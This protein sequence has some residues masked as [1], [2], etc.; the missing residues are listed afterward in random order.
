MAFANILDIPGVTYALH[1]YVPASSGWTTTSATPL[2]VVGS[3]FTIPGATD[4]SAVAIE[5]TSF[6]T[7]VLPMDGR[8]S[9]VNVLGATYPNE[10]YGQGVTVV[11]A[12]DSFAAQVGTTTTNPF[13]AAATEAVDN[14]NRFF[15]LGTGLPPDG[16]FIS[17]D[18][19][20]ELDGTFAVP[21]FWQAFDGTFE[22][23]SL[24]KLPQLV[25]VPAFPGVVGQDGGTVCFPPP[26][27]PPGGG[28]PPVGGGGGAGS[29][30][31]GGGGLP[32][33]ESICLPLNGEMCCRANQTAPWVCYPL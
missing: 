12:L 32:P 17:G 10:T 4:W 3:A 18:L 13:S 1:Y 29:S 15:V 23:G 6:G 33:D 14:D 2:A 25:A 5:I 7:G 16:Q 24:V 30:G 20:V 27:D 22:D 21:D 28:D 31:D 26:P 11:D 9:A 8:I 19:T